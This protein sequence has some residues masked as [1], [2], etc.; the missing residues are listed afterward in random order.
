MKLRISALAWAAALFQ[1]ATC[2]VGI[3]I[4]IGMETIHVDLQQ[5]QD[6]TE[7]D[8]SDL[9]AVLRSWMEEDLG[10]APSSL[11]YSFHSCTGGCDGCINM[12]DSMNGGLESIY[13]DLD[14]LYRDTFPFSGKELVLSRA[15][16]N[17]LAGIVAVETTI[18]VNNDICRGVPSC[19][20]KEVRV[21]EK[22][23]I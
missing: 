21:G 20:M 7:D 5:N 13:A 16:L 19:D 15:D 6:W 10:R 3:N 8:V 11:R 9:K 2:Q 1:V 4:G 23:V 17:A 14:Q 12:A 22:L 18:Q